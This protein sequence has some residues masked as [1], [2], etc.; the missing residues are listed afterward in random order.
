M[1]AMLPLEHLELPGATGVPHRHADQEAVELGLG[2]GKSPLVFDR[3][4]GGKDDEWLRQRM[5]HAVDGDLTLLHRFQQ[6]GLSLRCGAVDLV[7]E[8]ELGYDRTRTV[9][10]AVSLL[11]EDIDSGHV[12]GEE[13][14]G[15]LNALEGAAD[16][17]CNCLGQDRLANPGDVLDENVTAAEQGYEDEEHLVPLTDDNSLD[18]IADQ[19]RNTLDS[20]GIHQLR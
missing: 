7:G 2:Q 1:R 10:E 3:V 9:F 5:S 13:I 12:A 8:D 6:R 18:V 17:A 11:V 20:A 4:L 16:R 19:A 15:E 14:G